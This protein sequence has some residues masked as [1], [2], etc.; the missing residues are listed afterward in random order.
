MS[1]S[2]FGYSL[3]PDFRGFVLWISQRRTARQALVVVVVVV[4]EEH[5]TTVLH[6]PCVGF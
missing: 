5:C 1:S 3:A 4:V 2:N 6:A